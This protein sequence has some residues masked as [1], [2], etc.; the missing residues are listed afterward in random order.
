MSAVRRLAERKESHRFLVAGLRLVDLSPGCIQIS[1]GII[2]LRCAN[3]IP[4]RI[5]RSERPV[6]FEDLLGF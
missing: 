5:G 3:F 4:L 6:V 1:E 2:E